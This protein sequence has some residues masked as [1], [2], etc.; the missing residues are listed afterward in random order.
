MLTQKTFKT[1]DSHGCEFE[2]IC[3][4]VRNYKG[5]PIIE[6]HYYGMGFDAITLKGLQE[7]VGS[8]DSIRSVT[9]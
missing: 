7:M 1:K 4:L 2:C 5:G 3:Q 8:I 9:K 6:S